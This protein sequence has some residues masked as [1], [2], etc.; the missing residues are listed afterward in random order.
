MCEGALPAPAAPGKWHPG[1][2]FGRSIQSVVYV[3]FMHTEDP[4]PHSLLSALPPPALPL[5]SA[6]S[7]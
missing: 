4:P 6:S 1:F 3:L 7:V 2:G 5:P